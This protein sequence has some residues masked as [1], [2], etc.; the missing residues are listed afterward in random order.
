MEKDGKLER[1]TSEARAVHLEFD[2]W[3]RRV[4]EAPAPPEPKRPRPAAE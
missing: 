1:A 2:G 4:V 3:K